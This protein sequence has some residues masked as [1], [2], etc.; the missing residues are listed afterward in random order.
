M[1]HRFVALVVTGLIIVA[2][3]RLLP[4]LRTPGRRTAW[5]LAI[6]AGALVLAQIGLGAA[7]VLSYLNPAVVTAHLGV[8]ALLLGDLWLLFLMTGPA[9]E[10]APVLA[11]Q[12]MARTAEA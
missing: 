10:E 1:L 8:G 12:R 4:E 3:A 9:L 6:A 7:S 11:P 5:A 2:M